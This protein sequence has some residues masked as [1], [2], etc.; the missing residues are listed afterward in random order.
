MLDL[1]LFEDYEQTLLYQN[2][3]Y[4]V[5]VVMK[6]ILVEYVMMINLNI[7]VGITSPTKGKSQRDPGRPGVR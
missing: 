4:I 3:K 5:I 6:F 7:L 1:L 2:V